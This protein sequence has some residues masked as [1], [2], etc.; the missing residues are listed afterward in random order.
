MGVPRL[1][2][3]APDP[4]V[5]EANPLAD[6]VAKDGG[7]M[8]PGVDRPLVEGAPSEPVCDGSF[9]TRRGR[10]GARI[11]L[12][13]S[14]CFHGSAGGPRGAL[15]SKTAPLEISAPHPST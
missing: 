15:F 2:L 1:L 11:G 9:P 8:L 13:S 10:A 12:T 7:P 6:L 3:P 5:P 14:A 4:G